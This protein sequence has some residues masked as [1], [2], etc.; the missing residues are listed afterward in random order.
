[1]ENENSGESVNGREQKKITYENLR[2]KKLVIQEKSHTFSESIC[3][4][5]ARDEIYVHLANGQRR[6]ICKNHRIAD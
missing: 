3:C 1:M 6:Y 4:L 2:R 5:N